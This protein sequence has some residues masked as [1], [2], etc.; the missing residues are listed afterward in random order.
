MKA[1]GL[2]ESAV[3]ANLAKLLATGVLVKDGYYRHTR[4]FRF[5]L[6]RL[7]TYAPPPGRTHAARQEAARRREARNK[8]PQTYTTVQ[9]SERLRTAR[10]LHGGAANPT[11][12]WRQPYTVVES[13]LHRSGPDL[14]DLQD[15]QDLTAA[16]AAEPIRDEGTEDNSPA[17]RVY[18]ATATAA[19]DC[20]KREGDGSQ[21]NVIEHFKR[22]CAE[23]RLPYDRV[24]VQKAT[25]AALIADYKARLAT[26]RTTLGPHPR[27]RPKRC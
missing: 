2:E 8:A 24:I 15:Q 5:D 21:G 1:M 12:P 23:Q 4:R 20:A 26:L 10:T 17:F 25:D 11:R 27:R 19:I 16:D 14:Q 7:S 9:G 6:E 22:L 3:R 18:A 13:N